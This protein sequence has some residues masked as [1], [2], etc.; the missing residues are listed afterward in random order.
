MGYLPF[1]IYSD[2]DKLT[3]EEDMLI[4]DEDML[5]YFKDFCKAVMEN[6]QQMINQRVIYYALGSF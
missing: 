6:M 5:A 4:F 1:D 2:G 3:L